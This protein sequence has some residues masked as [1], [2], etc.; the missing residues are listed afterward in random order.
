VHVDFA[1]LPIDHRGARFEA[2][3]AGVGRDEGFVE[4][5]RGIF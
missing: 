1:V 4:D 5:Q 3:M 2:L